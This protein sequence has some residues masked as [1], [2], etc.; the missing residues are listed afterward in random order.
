VTALGKPNV[1]WV[2]DTIPPQ[3]PASGHRW[4]SPAMPSMHTKGEV[5]TE[6]DLLYQRSLP[7]FPDDKTGRPMLRPSDSEGLLSY[8]TVPYL[9]QPLLLSFFTSND[10][11]N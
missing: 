3:P 5:R 8:L 2:T 11:S 1:A 6:D 10:R 4:P 7:S 9:R